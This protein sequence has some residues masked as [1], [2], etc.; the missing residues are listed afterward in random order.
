MLLVALPWAAFLMGLFQI[1]DGEAGVMPEGLH[2]FMAEQFF[3]VVDIGTGSDE[4]GGTGATERVGR[5]VLP[6]AMTS[7]QGAHEPLQ[8]VVGNAVALGV[9]EQSGAILG[10]ATGKIWAHRHHIPVQVTQ[11]GLSDRNHALFVAFAPDQ[12]G[13]EILGSRNIRVRP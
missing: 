7:A 2:A 1:H 9:K 12:C 13:T 4:F 8:A 5:D 6:Q 3:V 10:I 11:R